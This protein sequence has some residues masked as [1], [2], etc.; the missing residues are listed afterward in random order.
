[1]NA[2]QRTAFTA[3][4]QGQ[5]LS[6]RAVKSYVKIAARAGETD[7]L[8]FLRQSITSDTPPGTASPLKA[9]VRHWLAYLGRDLEVVKVD[10]IKAASHQSTYRVALTADVLPAYKRLVQ[11]G[12]LSEPYRTIALLLPV[13]GLRASEV[14]G[15]LEADLHTRGGHHGID[16]TGKGGKRRWVPLI[17][18]AAELI[19]AYRKTLP[20]PSPFLFPSPR[21]L[22]KPSSPVT[23]RAWLKKARNR[24]SDADTGLGHVHPHLLRHTFATLALG[25]GVELRELQDLLGHANINTTAIYAQPT[26]ERLAGAV[27]KL[28]GIMGGNDGAE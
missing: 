14:C 23:L 10:R 16:L 1:M 17:P 22:D 19:F 8:E 3:Y 25:R 9:A 18:E 11:R 21:R 24:I 28:A 13:T 12:I 20:G 27:G 7:P 2:A 15:L 26:P 4:L 6:E 5:N